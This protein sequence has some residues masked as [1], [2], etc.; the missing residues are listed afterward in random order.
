MSQKWHRQE[1]RASQIECLLGNDPAQK[2]TEGFKF[3]RT[4]SRLKRLTGFSHIA[5]FALL[6]VTMSAATLHLSAPLA[7]AA[8]AALTW[9][10]PTTNTDG[11]AIKSLAGYKV[12]TGTTSGSYSQNVDVGNVT[13]Y[14][15]S[16]LNDGTT[17]YFA[18]TAY[19][20]SGNTSGY[21]NQAT[22]STA[23]APP[24]TTLY[25]L[26]AS[27]GSGGSITPSGATVVSSGANQSY[28][29]TASS[30][31]K[32]AGVTVDGASIGAVTSYT[33][34]KVAASHSISATFST[35]SAATYTVTASTG[36]GG[37]VTPA[38]A[39]S[40][41]AGASKS[42]TVTP[43]AGYYVASVLVDGTS[44]ASNIAGGAGYTYSFSSVSANHTIS[45]TF[46][47]RSYHIVATAGANGTVTPADGWALY[48]TSQAM[49]FTPASGYQVANVTLDGTSLGAV[50]SYTFNNLAADHTL[51]VTFGVKVPTYTITA[52]AGANG[53]ITPSTTVNQGAS[54]SVTVTPNKGYYV[55]SVAVDGTTVAS[56]LPSGGY[57]YAFSNVT[58]NHT[59]T[60]TFGVR[61]YEI[62]ASAGSNG[63]VSPPDSWVLYNTPQTVTIT[64]ASGY[65]IASVLVD[66]VSVGAVSSYTFSN[67]SAAH[68]L[69]ATFQ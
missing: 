66:G 47:V 34:S 54:Q 22:F 18:V 33:F 62:A 23:A 8:Q 35:T 5:Y 37:S 7:Q 67:I 50:S 46:A 24:T 20:A 9:S 13:S 38:G 39:T 1:S 32:V 60:A 31:Y 64:P 41:A 27:A 3:M 52:S 36:T 49:T 44:V 58:A 17:Y 43:S 25:T 51:S 28:T 45:A 10:A 16:S 14:T 59:V 2:L 40:L 19:D 11:T 68:T 6:F 69:Q 56:N 4:T 26:T 65:K 15:N 48:N 63:S 29:I 42:Y 57:S 12:S 61:Y 21:S 53:T 30:G 55:V